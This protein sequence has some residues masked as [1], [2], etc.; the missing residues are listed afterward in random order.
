[1][2]KRSVVVQYE[3]QRGV[4]GE[5]R[6]KETIYTQKEM[7]ATR[8][9]GWLHPTLPPRVLVQVVFFI[10]RTAGSRSQAE[11]PVEA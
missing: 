2:K 11:R 5:G 7:C 4:R 9:E 3:K 10:S 1:M 6:R 8:K